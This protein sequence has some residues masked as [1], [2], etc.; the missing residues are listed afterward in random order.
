[1]NRSATFDHRAIVA[2][3][4]ALA[5]PAL[6][7]ALSYAFDGVMSLAGLS[8][9]YMAAVAAA[10]AAL[11]RGPAAFSALLS[12]TALNVG[13]VPPRGSLS[14]GEGEYWWILAA[15]LG[16]SLALGALVGSLRAK[17]AEAETRRIRVQELHR[18]G[19]AMAAADGADAMA[20]AAATALRE[21]TG[22]PCAIFLHEPHG[23]RL[24]RFASTEDEAFDERAAAWAIDNGRPVGP[25]S[26]NWPDLPVWCAPFARTRGAGAVQVRIDGDTGPHAPRSAWFAAPRGGGPASGRPGGGTAPTPSEAEHWSALARQAGLALERERAAAAAAHAEQGARAEAARNTL[27]ASLSHDLRTPLAGI[28]GS[29]SALRSQGAEMTA[30]QRSA[31]LDNLEH[32]ARDL[33]LMADNILQIA[34]LSQPHTG[35]ATQWESIEDV[36]GA[37]V[38]RMRRRWPAATIQLNVPRG[39][40]VVKVE[41]GLLAQSIANLVDNAVRHGGDPPRVVVQAGRSRAGL[42]VAVRDHG[43]GLPPGDLDALFT[44]WGRGESSRAG[45]SGLGLAICR[46]AAEGH[47]GSISARSCE[48]G[49]E[50]RIELPAAQALEEA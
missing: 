13:F 36:L 50:F 23:T 1:L 18:L 45:G 3:L 9:F 46:L 34:R 14:V 10:A 7:T 35:L 38:T 15:L 42:F 47:G 30:Q 41:A 2:W 22:R 5:S 39:L 49:A 40:P 48:P 12:V 29:A 25:G 20:R 26:L 8:M 28:V 37:A 19:E 27:L 11:P 33:A 21:A 31:L 32:E 43:K 4:A 17:R 44:R 24:L 6:A 16:L